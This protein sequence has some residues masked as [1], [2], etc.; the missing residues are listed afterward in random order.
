MHLRT[1]N[2]YVATSLEDWRKSAFITAQI[3]RQSSSGIL[4]IYG[5]HDEHSQLAGTSSFGMSGVN[6]HALMCPP[7]CSQASQVSHHRQHRTHSRYWTSMLLHPMLQCAIPV[8][9]QLLLVQ[10]DLNNFR[11]SYLSDHQVT[12]ISN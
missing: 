10:S 1:V 6:A 5:Y 3:P 2:T 8:S 4:S 11:L 7:I 9:G 12:W